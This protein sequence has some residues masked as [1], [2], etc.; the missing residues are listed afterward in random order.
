MC[1]SVNTNPTP[2]QTQRG[3]VGARVKVGPVPPKSMRT[4]AHQQSDVINN[5]DYAWVQD[6]ASDWY[7]H[8]SD[9]SELE[10]P[11]PDT[12]EDAND[13]CGRVVHVLYG[14][15]MVVVV[16]LDA[17]ATPPLYALAMFRL[18]AYEPEE[19]AESN[20]AAL[21]EASRRGTRVRFRAAEYSRFQERSP[22]LDAAEAQGV[23]PWRV[24]VAT[25]AVVI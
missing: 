3:R 23:H 7:D 9:L 2:S 15:I 14:A 4:T 25:N 19:H 16:L 13:Y 5:T 17:P 11:F 1:V 20:R 6:F 12:A 22:F 21:I 8:L 18:R 10:L 24:L